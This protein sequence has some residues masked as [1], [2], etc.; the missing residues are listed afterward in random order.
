MPV[1]ICFV[2][3]KTMNIF[4]TRNVL[5][6]MLDNQGKENSVYS[7]SHDSENQV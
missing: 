3:K 4:V 7:A 1:Y 2:P 5:Q 6:D